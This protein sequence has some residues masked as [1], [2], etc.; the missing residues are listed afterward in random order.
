MG[1]T[2]SFS[3]NDIDTSGMSKD[4]LEALGIEA[5]EEELEEEETEEEEEE[6]EESEEEEAE[7]EEPEEEEEEEKGEKK[8]PRIPKS[9]FDEAVQKE[10]EQRIR[11]EE[12]TKYLEEQIQRLEA[13]ATKVAVKEEVVEEYDFDIAEGKY[14]ELLISGE[15]DE[16]TKLRREINKQRDNQIKSLIKNIKSEAEEAVKTTTRN[17]SERD[18]KAIVIEESIVKYPFLNSDHADFDEKLVKRINYVSAGYET[19]G[20]T[21]SQALKTAIEE[22]VPKTVK[23]T[24]EAK[25]KEKVV[26]ISKQPPKTDTTKRIKSKELT[27]YDWEE[28]SQEDFRKLYKESPDLVNKY[29]RRVN[30]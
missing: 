16:A 9:R 29:L 14:A 24:S 21:P 2:V 11:L 6:E 8:E 17:L 27:E 13:L 12:K 1:K 10:R 18:K 22:L 20:L 19:E 26:A 23:P 15:V 5:E 30:P 3:Y 25:K 28:M 4:E 7:E